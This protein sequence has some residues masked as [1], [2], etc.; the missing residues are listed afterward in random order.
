LSPL[1]SDGS[2]DGRA[3]AGPSEWR[4][5][6]RATLSHVQSKGISRHSKNESWKQ[7]SAAR[8]LTKIDRMTAEN[9]IQLTLSHGVD[10]EGYFC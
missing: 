2:H 10:E 1:R 6:S 7:L 5:N 3:G 9:K 8:D 4:R